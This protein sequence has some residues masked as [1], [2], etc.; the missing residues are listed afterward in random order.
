MAKFKI[1]QRVKIVRLLDEMTSRDLIG[2]VGTIV[3]VEPL[4]N[5]ETNYFVDGHYMH[6]AEL[7]SVE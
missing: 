6:E 1:G 7:E 5:G 3:E 2:K 4:P